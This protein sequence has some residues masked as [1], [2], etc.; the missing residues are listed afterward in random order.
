M[1]TRTIPILLALASAGACTLPIAALA[2][3]APQ[4]IE[5]I[6]VT[7]SN[8]KRVDAETASPITIINREDI[9]RSGKPTIAEVLRDLP[10]NGG[11]SFN[12]T[13]T[14]SFA[15]GASGIALR[16]LSQKSTLVLVNGRRMAS[17]GFAQNLFDTFVDLNAIPA[18]AVERIEILRDGASAVYGSDAIAGVVNV[19]LRKDYQGFEVGGT[20]GTSTEGGLNEYR[21]NLGF[22]FGSIGK[23]RYNLLVALDHYRRDELFLSEREFTREQD[24]RNREGGTLNRATIAVY[25][26][27]NG[28]PNALGRTPF[29]TCPAANNIDV[30]LI[31]PALT[32]RTCVINTA[33]LTSVFPKTERTGVLARGTWEMSQNLTAVAEAAYSTSK[34]TNTSF[35]A[36]VGAANIAYNPATS[37]VRVVAGT[38]PANNS[39]NPFGRPVNF[40]YSFFDVGINQTIVDSDAWRALAG[41]KG[42]AGSWDWEAGVGAA[43]TETRSVDTNR[44]NG[45]LLEQAIANNT[46]NFLNPS[47]GTVT[48]RDL[49]LD[50]FRTS[51]SELKFADIKATTELLQM[52]HGPLGFATGLDYRRES[53]DDVPDAN[54]AAG[55]VLGRGFTGTVG[56]RNATAAYAE[57]SIPLHAHVEAQVAV[58]RDK[59]SDF[60]SA[61]SPKLALKWSPAKTFLL[62]G[63]V[64]SGFRAPTLPEAAQTNAVSFITVT[65]PL[66]NRNFN[67]GSLS[68]SNPA[69]QP[70]KSRNKSGGFI[71]EPEKDFSVGVDFYKLRLNNVVAR[72]SSG[73]IIAQAIAGNPLFVNKV[74]RDPATNQII[75]IIRQQRNLGFL[76]TSGADIDLRKVFRTQENGKFTVVSSYNYVRTYRSAIT[77]GSTPVDFVDS[78]GFG[79]IPRLKGNASLTWEKSDWVSS[80]TYRYIHSYDQFLI[81]GQNRVGATYDFDGFVGYNGFKNL[82]ITLSARNLLDR[83][84]AWDASGGALGFDFTQYDLRGRYVTLGLR[85]TFK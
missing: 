49:R 31:N 46:Y 18:S 40:I 1:K 55:R 83:E 57:L 48:A 24:F 22:G 36:Q 9:E 16:G 37:G 39:S 38:L 29:S 63:S 67:I 75:Y 13:F 82:R 45:Q 7:G 50:L 56:S 74:I 85:Y 33:P 43:K 80:L 51:D 81:G 73:F 3:N 8:I 41:L 25:Q 79:A 32:G 78:N 76:E 70:E 52:A 19:I 4:R 64:S 34:S 2:Q 60:G 65:D 77:P 20:A 14:N 66:F 61:N 35:P 47:A 30:S 71:W 27:L 58:R 26:A 54:V 53:I 11:Q 17:Y 84:P 12:E 42:T 28:V 62:R 68:Q 59:Y 10:Q 15:P 6:E 23:D 21:A 5:K 72:D 44:V 69:L